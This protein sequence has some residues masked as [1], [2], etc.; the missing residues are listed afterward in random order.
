MKRI[1]TLF[2]TLL[3][4]VSMLFGAGTT[5]AQ[6]DVTLTIWTFGSFFTDFTKALKPTTRKSRPMSASWS[7]R[8]PMANSTT[9]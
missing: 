6:D 5:S 7:K 3:L 1:I 9:T 4:L 8:S 2:S